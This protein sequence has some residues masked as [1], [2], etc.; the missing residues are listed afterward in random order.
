MKPFRIYPTVEELQSNPE[1][2]KNKIQIYK[3]EYIFYDQDIRFGKCVI[4][5]KTQGSG[6]IKGTQLHHVWYNDDEPLEATIEVCRKCHYR[7]DPEKRL[8]INSRI[9]LPAHYNIYKDKKTSSTLK[10]PET[11]SKKL[12]KSKVQKKHTNAFERWKV[13]DEEFLIEF[14]SDAPTTQ[15]EDKKIEELMQKLGRTR[16]GIGQKLM[17]FGFH[18]DGKFAR[19]RTRK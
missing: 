15:N 8:A 14:W 4:C 13:S 1:Y 9:G 10:S 12:D 2:Y 7:I 6:E 17:S 19:Y 5:K 11:T 3:G 18:L 16:N